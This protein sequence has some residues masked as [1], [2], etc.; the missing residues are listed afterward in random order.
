MTNRSA[1]ILSGIIIIMA[2]AIRLYP[3]TANLPYVL[4]HDE[5]NY[6]ETA[7]RFGTGN[8]TMATYSHGGLFQLMLFAEYAVY[9][10]LL[11]FMRSVS[12]PIG[13]L[14]LY[15]K[16]PSVF[17]IIAR[18]TAAACAAG[19]AYLSFLIGKKAFGIRTGIIACIFASF[20]MLMTQVSFLALADAPAVLILASAIL[21]LIWSIRKTNGAGFYYVACFIIGMAC[22]C[23]Y[24]GVFGMAP[25][26]VAAFF[27][28]KDS[29]DRSIFTLTR[30][31]IFG[32][33]LSLAGFLV[34]VPSIILNLHTFY[35]DSVVRMGTEYILMDTNKN[36]WLYCFTWHLKNGLGI[37]LE[38]TALSGISYAFYKRTRED[39]LLLSFPVSYYL[40]VMNATA[41][42]QHVYP[43]A[44]FVLILGAR[45]IS[46][47][48]ERMNTKYR[49]LIALTLAIAITFPT[50]TDSIKFIGIIKSRDTRIMA[51]RWIEDNISND[52][53]ILE[54]GYV[55]RTAS[56]G[57]ALAENAAALERD[58][59]NVLSL[60]GSG[61]LVKLKISNFDTLYKGIKRYDIFKADR[62][63]V[64]DIMENDPSYIIL[65]GDND[66]DII[67]EFSYYIEK[68]HLIER[69]AVKD[70]IGKRYRL[71]KSF[72]PSDEFSYYFPLLLNNDYHVIRGR[73]LHD[74]RDCVKGPKID[75][76][77]KIE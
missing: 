17:F 9:Y 59:K 74:F 40:L 23:K 44:F 62:L 32:T 15:L 3:V 61:F 70:E 36:K 22:A 2:L 50:F 51:K 18:A 53:T 73:S 5:N 30:L 11:K 45:L 28:Y 7:L 49:S 12:S 26:Y 55:N 27:I 63:A 6:I 65:T 66:M 4:C 56:H 75:I 21:L 25:A 10:I 68:R 72:Q 34:S 35:K 76:Y 37:P 13:F 64:K 52:D 71:V 60:K 8:F 29:H 46:D 48:S 54:E 33:A 31:L 39:I 41:L 57:P 14:M 1:N 24:Y 38:L 47:F 58:L 69:V 20:S 77:K 67:T 43:M 16:D 42:A 19:A